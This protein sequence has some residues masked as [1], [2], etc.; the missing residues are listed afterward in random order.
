VRF[1]DAFVGHIDILKLGFAIKTL[2]T[3]GRPVS[4]A[5]FSKNLLIRLSQRNQGGRNL[6]RNVLETLK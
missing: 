5:K 2:K 1:I 4:T 3:E 6:E